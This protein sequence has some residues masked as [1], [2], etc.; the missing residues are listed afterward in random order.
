MFERGVGLV[1][2]L[3]ELTHLSVANLS[4]TIQI[5]AVFA[6]M[7]RMTNGFQVI[8]IFAIANAVEDAIGVRIKELPITPDKIIKALS[9]RG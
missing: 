8:Y 4:R 1:E 6:Y 9:A 5:T 3:F 2:L 7:S